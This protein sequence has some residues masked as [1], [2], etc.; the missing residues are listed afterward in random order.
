MKSRG[1]LIWALCLVAIACCTWVSAA[2][3][4][5]VTVV[6]AVNTPAESISA[7]IGDVSGQEF[8]PELAQRVSEDV[9]SLGFYSAVD[10]VGEP[11][12]NGISLIVRVVEYPR[13]SA[14]RIE[15]NKQVSTEAILAAIRTK[16]GMILNR[17]DIEKDY[18]TIESLYEQARALAL[19]DTFRFDQTDPTVLVLSLIE[20]TIESVDVKGLRKTRPRVVLRELAYTKPGKPY[21]AKLIEE[22]LARV[23]SLELFDQLSVSQ[24]VGSSLD[25]LAVTLNT[26]ERR[27]G[28]FSFGAGYSDQKR[29]TGFLEVT[30]T[31]FRGLGQTIS[32]RYQT[33][34]SGGRESMEFSF[35]EP[36]LDKRGTSLGLSVYDRSLNRFSGSL[37]STGSLTDDYLERRKGGTVSLG[38]RLDLKN[39]L[40]LTVRSETTAT[41]NAATATALL[42][43]G[44][45]TATSLEWTRN[46]RDFDHNP[47]RGSMLSFGA[48]NAWASLKA[49]STTPRR[50]MVF[51]QFNTNLRFYFP[52][53]RPG[54]DKAKA[55][56]V[57]AL[58]LKAG[59]SVGSLPFYEQFFVGGSESVRGYPEDRFW[60]S[61]SVSLNVE[62]RHPLDKSLTVVGFVDAGDAWGGDWDKVDI[63][64]YTQ[65]KSFSPAIG[66]G[67]GIRFMTPLG[68][69]RIDLGFGDKS[70]RTH[71]SFG[72]VF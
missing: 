9:R 66:Y 10:V 4:T 56:N 50:S 16:P 28:N 12:D 48:T 31:N 41:E 5:G 69:I 27:T 39:R 60:G 15:G 54:K 20:V 43:D 45:T 65:H 32:A 44:N 29:L 47:T 57:L 11:A 40:Y 36:W 13:I 62:F 18:R 61:H 6:G 64:G 3:I 59:T 19:V 63:Q 37:F 55:P 2:P 70:T 68:P 1:G 52:L 67:A 24:D 46:T 51:Q 21:N 26:K 34:T 22:D 33:A 49:T 7:R 8:T 38:R 25:K 53:K 72:N 71:F 42:Q 14:I 58:R 35:S 30:D 17:N 23:Y